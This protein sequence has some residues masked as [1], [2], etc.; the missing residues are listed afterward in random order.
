[1]HM[2]MEFCE[3]LC[4]LRRK[5]GFLY[6]RS[7]WIEKLLSFTRVPTYKMDIA[8][9]AEKDKGLQIGDPRIVSCRPLVRPTLTHTE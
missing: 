4:L 8:V 5:L 9:K 2:G 6:Q 3:V 1:M 7:F